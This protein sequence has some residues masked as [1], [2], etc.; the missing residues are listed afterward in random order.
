[1]ADRERDSA[2]LHLSATPRERATIGITA[3]V[4]SDDY[5]ESAL[6]LT[7]SD[8]KN[9]T[10]DT[11]IALPRNM[12]LYGMLSREEIESDQAGSSP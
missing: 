10:L 5:D 8:Y 7:S 11:S 2:E 6:G 1:M 3:E 4:A 9:I 12:T